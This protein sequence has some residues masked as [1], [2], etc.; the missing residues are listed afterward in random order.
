MNIKVDGQWKNH[1]TFVK[2]D[3]TDFI[4]LVSRTI[5]NVVIPQEATIIGV[6]AFANCTS[7]KSVTFHD[8]INTIA[9]NAF[10]GCS[11]LV[12]DNLIIPPLVTI[13]RNASFGYCPKIKGIV[14]M[15][16]NVTDVENTAFV[17]CNAVNGYDFGINV[18]TIGSTAL[19]YAQGAVW[20]FR[21]VNPPTI[22]ANNFKSELSAIYVPDSAVNTYKG[23]TNFSAYASIIKPLSEYQQ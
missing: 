6:R 13:V 14:K 21:G 7:L 23:A 5:T 16:D 2:K 8:G 1:V 11:N 17:G 20:I 22:N 10:N 9:S 15:H 12:I 3:L 19:G 4:S 18:Q